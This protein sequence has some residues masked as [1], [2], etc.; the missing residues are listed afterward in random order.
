MCSEV[1]KKRVY[2]VSSALPPSV[3][4][5]GV[6]ALRTA[7]NLVYDYE[8]KFITRTKSPDTKLPSISVAPF[9]PV[10]EFSLLGRIQKYLITFLI[11]PISSFYKLFFQTKPELI[12]CF[13]VTWLGIITFWFNY[14]FWKVPIIYEL[15][16]MGSD[17]P[18]SKSRWWLFRLLSDYCIK[19]ANHINAISPLIYNYLIRE[20]YFSEAKVSLITNS[21]DTE[22]FKPVSANKKI[23]LRKSLGLSADTFVIVTVAMVTNRKGYPL[24]LEIIKKFPKDF[25]FHWF[26]IGNHSS[27]KQSVL[28]ENIKRELHKVNKSDNVTFTG[29]MQ[30]DIY[31]KLADLFV[32]T[33]NREGL[34]TAVLEAMSCSLPVVCKKLTG[35]TEF[36][37]TN[38]VE[39]IILDS[40]NA[41]LFANEIVELKNDKSLRDSMGVM[42]RKR[43]I[44][45]FSLSII[46]KEYNDL[47]QSLLESHEN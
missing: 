33:S 23:D 10:D 35:I 13:S 21:V 34:G 41:K 29:Y 26:F 12:H 19:N 16:L 15:T 17:T 32:F 28:V 7:E 31:L 4:G 6:R 5:A 8:I 47:Y 30:P 18:G 43:I 3:G 25:N 20:K 40:Q 24:I 37:Y 46:L 45:K 1:D 11:L 38:R 9:Q 2:I 42:G 39:G 27:N 14:L 44:E 22:R 36:I